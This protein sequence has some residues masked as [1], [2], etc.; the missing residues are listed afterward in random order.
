MFLIF[1]KIKRKITRFSHTFCCSAAFTCNK[2]PRV[3]CRISRFF[4]RWIGRNTSEVINNTANERRKKKP[5][6][7]TNCTT[8]AT[9]MTDDDNDSA[10]DSLAHSNVGAQVRQLPRPRNP[11]TQSFPFPTANFITKEKK[12]I[13][14][15]PSCERLS[16]CRT[17]FSSVSKRQ[18]D[19]NPTKIANANANI[20]MLEKHGSAH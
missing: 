15:E 7:S 20:E 8:S 18:G 4:R 2:C 6:P 16:M 3:D 13:E 11:S 17:M 14:S 10:A 9:A 5:S 19:G 1:G 12:K